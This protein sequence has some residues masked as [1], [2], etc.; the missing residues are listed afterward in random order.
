MKKSN[1]AVMLTS[2]FVLVSIL[3]AGCINVVDPSLPQAEGKGNVLVS[4]SI[5]KNA[6]MPSLLDFDIYEFIFTKTGDGTSSTFSK[7]RNESFVFSLDLAKNTRL[8]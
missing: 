5:G 6:L 1:I 3:I 7:N 4:F 8:R 2:I